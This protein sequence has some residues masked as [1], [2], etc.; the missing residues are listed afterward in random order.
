MIQCKQTLKHQSLCKKKITLLK[1]SGVMQGNLSTINWLKFSC[2]QYG[3]TRSDSI[4]F[5]L[6][7]SRYIQLTCYRDNISCFQTHIWSSHTCPT[8]KDF[9]CKLFPKCLFAMWK[10]KWQPMCLLIK[11]NLESEWIPPPLISHDY[12]IHKLSGTFILW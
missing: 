2:W 1:Q 3:L 12:V 11:W 8:G 5:L 4:T 6:C 7:R 10:P 9:S